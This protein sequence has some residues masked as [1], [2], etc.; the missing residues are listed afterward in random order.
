MRWIRLLFK[1]R[2]R[3]A[4]HTL[5]AIGAPESM[6]DVADQLNALGVLADEVAGSKRAS[7]LLV[8]L[9][10]LIETVGD[11]YEDEK[12]DKVELGRV[13]GSLWALVR[14]ARGR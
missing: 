3:E 10:N 4:V 9:A 2:V 5:R 11:A 6:Q 14:V 13:M 7:D 8:A 12:L 1:R